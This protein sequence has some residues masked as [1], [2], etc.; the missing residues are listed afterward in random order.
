MFE[1]IAPALTALADVQVIGFVVLG[2]V[3]GLVAG[4]LPGLGNIQALAVALPFT[5]GMDRLTA[6][7]FLSAICAAATYGGAIPAILVNIPG[8][9]AN[10]ATTV[11]GFPMAKKGE[12]A[13]ALAISATASALG[14]L[15]GIG[16]LILSIPIIKPVVLFFGPPETFML[17][18]LGLMTIAYAVQHNIVRGL[19]TAGIGILLSLVGFSSVTGVFRFPLGSSQYLWDGI[20]DVA[21]LTGIFGL[22]EAI[23]SGMHAREGRVAAQIQHAGF[24]G[25]LQG[26]KDVFLYPWTLV[27]SSVVGIV[28]GI[29]PGVGG[30]VSN[31]VAYA[32][33][34]Q[35]SK[36]PKIGKGS[37]EGLIAAES[38]NNATYGGD[39][40]P[41]LA[42]GIPGSAAMAVLMAGFTLHGIPV[43]PWLMKEH[44]EI[45]WVVVFGLLAGTLLS[46]VL[47]F[48]IARWLARITTVSMGVVVPVIVVLILAGSFAVRQNYWDVVVTI[49]SGVFGFFLVSH[50]YSLLPVIIGF[51]LA[52]PAE[53]AFIQS[54]YISEG[55][56]L[57]FFKSP[58]AMILFAVSIGVGLY[59]LVKGRLLEKERRSEEAAG[60]ANVS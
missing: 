24:Q 10:A 20:Q 35:M 32:M 44:M 26:V 22:S 57:I 6:I 27:R 60:R 14:G 29:A 49:V 18:L 9:P 40:V 38:S 17:V 21:F 45:V 11:E 1:G 3:I 8:T 52:G 2:S 39:A 12:G 46:C 16:S 50:G 53:L 37:I 48:L 23:R 54:L 25:A 5:F 42:F 33:T 59:P 28:V 41:T 15:I 55:S 58:I 51:L 31:V 34:A 7:Y 13:R 19:A 56:P 47:G 4:I 43:G 36:D 30:S